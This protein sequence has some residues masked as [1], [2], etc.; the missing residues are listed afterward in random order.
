M[1]GAPALSIIE[2]SVLARVARLGLPQ[3]ARVLDA[4]CGHGALV[5]ALQE[6]RYQAFGTDVVPLA[7]DLLGD[8]FLPADLGAGIPV[9]DASMDLVL[10]VEGIEHLEN[11]SAFLREIHRVL[12]PGG[13]CIVTTPNTVSI[14]SRVRF[15]GSGFYNQDP[16]PLN[17]SAR[18]PLHHISLKTFSDLRYALETSGLSLVD[19]GHTHI[20]PISF[21]YAVFHPWIAVYTKLAFRKEK[22]AAQRARN[23]EIHRALLSRSLLFGENV[24]IVARK[25]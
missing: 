25:R 8:A 10:A 13:F 19:A 17:E 1:P 18:H 4:P 7:A 14:R 2:R 21:V 22:D 6:A 9:A 15:L 20:K 16:R 5:A 24:M 11:P 12:R 3:G 23:E